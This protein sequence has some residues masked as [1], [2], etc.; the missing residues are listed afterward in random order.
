MG[1]IIYKSHVGSKQNFY[2]LCRVSEIFLDKHNNVCTCKV[3]FRARHVGDAGKEYV[4]KAPEEMKV[5]M[6]RFSTFLTVELQGEEELHLANDEDLQK[7]GPQRDMSPG[8]GIES[9]K[10]DR[11]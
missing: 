1:H 4:S 3:K 2:R 9:S 6:Q 8:M 5:A 10:E 7:K 11:G